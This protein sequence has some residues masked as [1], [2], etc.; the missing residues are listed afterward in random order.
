M[1]IRAR[2]DVEL[3]DMTTHA[4]S[5]HS[6]S[7]VLAH[8]WLTGMRGG[9]RVLES[10]ARAFPAAPIYTLIC[11]PAAIS[12]EI[13]RH[14]IVTSR[15]QHVPGIRRWYRHALP[16][17]P[18]AIESLRP[19]A[20]DV[21]V[22]V[23]H[24]VAKGIIPRPGARH[25]CYCLTPMR[26]AWTFYEDY[27]GSH[28]LKKAVLKPMLARLREWDRRTSGRVDR[29]VAIS[30]HVQQ[31]IREYYGR[32][33]DLVYPPVQT[34]FWTPAAPRAPRPSGVPP[35]YDLVVSALVPYK[36]VDLAVRAY[37][38]AGGALIV[39]GGGPEARR[40]RALAGPNIRFLE[41]LPDGE[42]REL[43]RHCRMLV[44]PGEEDF[45]IVP[46]EAQACG[47][48][49]AAFGRGGAL[50]TVADGVSGVFFREQTEDAL[51]D[52]VS[53][54]AARP[55]NPA[56]I[57]AQAEPFGEDRFLREIKAS[58]DRCLAGRPGEAPKGP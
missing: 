16:L 7:V 34:G 13:K 53:R 27:F 50:E 17:F 47:R 31:R 42:I 25:L 21:L 37:T 56:A 32:D 49:V 1:T 11:N 38:R 30:R 54:C 3:F 39:A 40:L 8:D 36:R 41:G 29:F 14:P 10:L 35:V 46:V 18:A 24:C 5:T 51:L 26:Y 48:P 23:S 2:R 4:T 9:E 12:A 33:S 43:Y 45:G 15:L 44:F 19:P 28:P 22:S 20:A 55:W 6:V 57:R 58:L 52:A